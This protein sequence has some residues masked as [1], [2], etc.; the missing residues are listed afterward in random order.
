MAALQES[1]RTL[2]PDSK[3]SRLAAALE[4]LRA[5]GH[6]QA[7]VFTQYTDTMDFLREELLAG[8]GGADRRI[9]CFSGRGGEVR[10]TAGSWKGV[11]RDEAE[12]RFQEGQ[13][14]VLPRADADTGAFWHAHLRAPRH[15]SCKVTKVEQCK[16]P[17]PADD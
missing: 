5:A 7:V 8:A 3:A 2:P 15:R 13:A 14:D 16:S 1:I 6:A 17:A 12:R 4:E 9:L 10:E 11:S